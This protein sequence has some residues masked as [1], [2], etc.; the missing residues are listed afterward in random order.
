MVFERV[1]EKG[2]YGA[3][4]EIKAPEVSHRKNSF[5]L[6]FLIFAELVFIVTLTLR[7]CQISNVKT[8]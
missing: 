7:L 5:F 8:T 2:P 6:L 1:W 4:I 3:E